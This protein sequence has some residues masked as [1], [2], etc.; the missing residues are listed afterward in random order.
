MTICPP[1]HL[2]ASA[3]SS[4]KACPERYHKA[5]DEGI[6]P[7]EDT[8][9][10]RIGTNWHLLHETYRSYEDA[11]EGFEAAI[12]A[13]NEI[14]ATIPA[15]KTA[16]EWATERAI[17]AGSFA[18]WIH[19]MP[20]PAPTLVTELQFELPLPHPKT[21]LPVGG[22]KLQGKIDRLVRVGP[23]RIA[24]RD[25]KSTSKP[26]AADSLFW[27]HLRLDTQISMYVYAARQLQQRGEL[28]QYGIEDD[29]EIVGAFYDVWHKPTIKDKNLTQAESAEFM[30]T[31]KYMG[32]EFDVQWNDR[33]GKTPILLI[34]G[35]EALVTPGKKDGTFAIRE[36]PD[37]F[38]AR[39]MFDIMER[40]EFYFASREIPRTD[41]DMETFVAQLYS[42]CQ[43]I[44]AARSG[45]HWIQNEQQCEATFRCPYIP[46]CYCH[47]DTSDGSTPAGFKRIGSQQAGY[48]TTPLTIEKE[49]VEL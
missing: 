10:L 7:I 17:L 36:T 4:F 15:T 49:H 35:V 24:V 29:D 9:G 34:N 38:C 37:M 31:I 22:V 47:V 45:G 19:L 46:M 43:A 48:N 1:I 6:R 3:I 27:A 28:R 30:D 13:L 32:Q 5:Y 44:K 41:A 14:Y 23:K 18:A 21:G 2:S 11:A 39:L 33:G 8:D 42:V 16:E 26:I 25:Y 12:A 20:E 40:Q